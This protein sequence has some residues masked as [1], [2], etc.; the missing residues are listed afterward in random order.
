MGDN[1]RPRKILQNKI[2]FRG[3]ELVLRI[4]YDRNSSRRA[5]KPSLRPFGLNNAPE[6]KE[7]FLAEKRIYAVHYATA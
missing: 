3:A 5:C 1:V 4:V 6:S 2:M 7:K